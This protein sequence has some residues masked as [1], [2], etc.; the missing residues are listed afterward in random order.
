MYLAK[1]LGKVIST[2][3]YP[4]YEHKKLLVVQRLGLDRKPSGL[5]TVAI[6][7]VGAGE[8]DIV[9]VGAAPGLASTVFK[10]PKA[11]IREL[12]M[13]V[14]DRVDIPGQEPF[15]HSLPSSSLKSSPSQ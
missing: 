14:V 4:A 15:G 12:I 3:K 8:G 1:V 6:D 2:D 7:Y 11:P 9:L 10:V 5:P 13:G